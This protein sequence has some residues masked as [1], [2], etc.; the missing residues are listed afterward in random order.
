MLHAQNPKYENLFGLACR[1]FLLSAL[2]YRSLSVTLLSPTFTG[3]RT[4]PTSFK[5]SSNQPQTLFFFPPPPPLTLH[6]PT[7][8]Q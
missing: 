4:R 7:N 8:T 5:A 2:I 6:P 1:L 3:E